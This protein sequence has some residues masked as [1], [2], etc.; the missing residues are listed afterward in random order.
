MLCKKCAAQ[1]ISIEK[2]DKNNGLCDECY[3]KGGSKIGRKMHK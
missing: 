3:S 2:F 1:G